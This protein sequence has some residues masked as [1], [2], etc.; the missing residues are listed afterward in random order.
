MQFFFNKV[1]WFH[2]LKPV[3]VINTFSPSPRI[4]FHARDSEQC[5]DMTSSALHNAHTHPFIPACFTPRLHNP[6]WMPPCIYIYIYIHGGIQGGLW[7]RGVKQAGMNGWVW[8]LCSAD[9]VISTHC[10]ESLAWKRIR[11]DGE[12]VLITCT[13]F[14]WWNQFTLLKK[15]CILFVLSSIGI[16]IWLYF[17]AHNR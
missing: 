1:N 7:S 15:N 13:G 6:P 11:G 14:N 8:A 9:D 17:H 10:S 2:Q 3:Q 16:A 12:N 4:L 5:V